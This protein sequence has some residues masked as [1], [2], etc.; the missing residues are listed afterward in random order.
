VEVKHG[1]ISD[2][3]SAPFTSESK[4]IYVHSNKKLYGGHGR[5]NPRT[6]SFVLSRSNWSLDPWYLELMEFQLRKWFYHFF[7][8]DMGRYDV[9]IGN[10]LRAGGSGVGIPEE[11]EIILSLK[12]TRPSL[13]HTV[14]PIQG[15]PGFFRWVKREVNHWPPYMCIYT[16]LCPYPTAMFCVIVGFFP[17]KIFQRNAPSHKGLTWSIASSWVCFHLTVRHWTQSSHQ[18]WFPLINWYIIPL[19]VV[20]AEQNNIHYTRDSL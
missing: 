1:L 2:N 4:K 11:T 7:N 13:E 19:A 18:R 16:E 15:V 10:T 17:L 12:I 14:F 20:I 9:D 5:K 6:S 3:R 8:S